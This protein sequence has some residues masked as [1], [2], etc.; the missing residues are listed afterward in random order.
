MRCTLSMISTVL[1]DYK[2]N[3]KL[4][5]FASEIFLRKD[6]RN[7]ESKQFFE[8]WLILSENNLLL[9]FVIPS[10]FSSRLRQVPNTSFRSSELIGWFGLCCSKLLSAWIAP[11]PSRLVLW[12]Q[13]GPYLPWSFWPFTP[14][15]WLLSWLPARSGTISRGWMIPGWPIPLRINRPWGLVRFLGQ[16]LRRWL[17]KSGRICT[18]IWNL[19]IG[20]MWWMESAPWNAGTYGLMILGNTFDLDLEPPFLQGFR[21]LH[22]R[23]YSFG[24]L[25]CTRR[26]M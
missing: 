12:L 1:P 14:L 24:I 11:G 4:W 15:H 7:F 25:S 10:S 6:F 19:T 3:Q 5:N 9:L 23:C 18:C 21:C 26:R 17:G 22:L 8:R 16:T 13:F 20:P 2:S